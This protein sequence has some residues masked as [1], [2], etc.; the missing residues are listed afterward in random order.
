MNESRR[1]P[2]QAKDF[3]PSPW[4]FH[5]LYVYLPDFKANH[6]SIYQVL[7][8]YWNAQFGYAFPTIAEIQLRT[9]LSD[10]TV[11]RVITDLVEWGLIEVRRYKEGGNNTYIVHPPIEDEEIFFKRFPEAAERKREREK[12]VLERANRPTA[13]QRK[14]ISTKAPP[15]EPQEEE[16]I[17]NW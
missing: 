3:T 17:D 9:G 13:S 10:R 12:A 5:T 2:M 14:K 11:D 6:I 16:I 8:H 7:Y 1:K 4:V 15:P